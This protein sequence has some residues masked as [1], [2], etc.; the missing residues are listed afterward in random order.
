MMD[1]QLESY[2][3]LKNLLQQFTETFSPHLDETSISR[4]GVELSKFDLHH[5]TGNEDVYFLPMTQ[6][7][8]KAMKERP[9]IDL[10]FMPCERCCI[11]DAEEVDKAISSQFFRAQDE[12]SDLLAHELSPWRLRR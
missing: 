3:K 7:R 1:I 10:E 6:T 9:D 4:L 12:G 11:T 5:E 8:V 2:K